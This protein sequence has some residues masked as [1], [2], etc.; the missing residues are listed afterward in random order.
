MISITP[1]VCTQCYNILHLKFC[2]K[3]KKKLKYITDKY[4]N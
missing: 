4:K 1:K 2:D 3:K